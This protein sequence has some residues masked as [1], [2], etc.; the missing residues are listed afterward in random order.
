SSDLSE[1]IRYPDAQDAEGM[2]RRAWW[3]VV[4]N[5]LVPGSAQVLAGNRRLGRFG[6]GATLLGWFLLVVAAGL[7][8][9]AQGV[10]VWFATGPL[11][12][13]LLTLAQVLLLGYVVLWVVLTR[14]EEHT[15]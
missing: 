8:L 15:S 4:M 5:V 14:S 7:G 2:G 10:M 1:P 9:F 11:S 13:F 12:W 6:L 3:L